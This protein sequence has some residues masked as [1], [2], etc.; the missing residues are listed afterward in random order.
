MFGTAAAGAAVARAFGYGLD[1]DGARALQEVGRLVVEL[2]VEEL[3][4]RR[5]H[6]LQEIRNLHERLHDVDA[7]LLIVVEVRL[8]RVG[9]EADQLGALARGNVAVAVGVSVR[10][11]RG[12]LGLLVR[13]QPRGLKGQARSLRLEHED[14]RTR[15]AAVRGT[16]AGG[17]CPGGR[18]AAGVAIAITVTA[19]CGSRA[20]RAAA[21]AVVGT[22]EAMAVARGGPRRIRR[23]R[24]DFIRHEFL[25][26]VQAG[27]RKSM[28]QLVI[29]RRGAHAQPGVGPFDDRIFVSFLHPAM[30]NRILVGELELAHLAIHVN[31]PPLL[32]LRCA[33]RTGPV[34]LKFA[35]PEFER[36]GSIDALWSVGLHQ[37]KNG[38]R[39]NRA[40]R[41]NPQFIGYTG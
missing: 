7:R 22:A 27:D 12:V 32:E 23:Q 3:L 35:K 17:R 37:S 30:H 40:T 11:E 2:D 16:I 24:G 10:P 28:R 21:E 41:C 36:M 6:R 29:G 25:D 31:L 13:L 14:Q 15:R 9:R 26:L 38:E 19:G 4:P 1:L 20:G 33:E 39:R 5:H 34:V 8:A 18:A